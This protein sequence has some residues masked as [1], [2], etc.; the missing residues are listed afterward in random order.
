MT[1]AAATHAAGHSHHPNYVAIWVW[2]IILT[3]IEVSIPEFLHIPGR[4]V[5]PNVPVV[6]PADAYQGEEVP[7]DIR[8]AAASMAPSERFA[9]AGWTVRIVS[10]TVLAIIKMALVGVFF[11]HLKFDGW[12]LNAILAAPTALFIFIIIMLTP[13]VAWQWPQLY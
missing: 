5:D 7:A 8:E 9:I 12:K 2:L 4:G 10:L 3:A 13:D 1:S 11:M 6:L